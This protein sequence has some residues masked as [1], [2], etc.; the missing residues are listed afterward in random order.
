MG[1]GKLNRGP[2]TC[3]KLEKADLEFSPSLPFSLFWF[4]CLS[5]PVFVS[6]GCLSIHPSLVTVAPPF[7]WPAASPAEDGSQGAMPRKPRPVLAP[8]L[9]VAAPPPPPLPGT[10]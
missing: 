9:R 3:G 2:N 10:Q 6:G 4:V 8:P 7:W 1:T 5:A